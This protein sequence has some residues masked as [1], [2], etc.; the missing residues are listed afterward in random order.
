MV[1]VQVVVLGGSRFGDA[2]QRGK[3]RAILRFQRRWDANR[4]RLQEWN[5][6]CVQSAVSILASLQFS[7][8]VN[9]S[10]IL[11]KSQ[12]VFTGITSRSQVDNFVIPLF[13]SL[14]QV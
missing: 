4:G 7:F 6:C 12:S 3:S 9:S 5:V 10:A 1:W 14:T 11:K 2:R 8:T 13:C